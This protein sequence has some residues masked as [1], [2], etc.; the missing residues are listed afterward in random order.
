MNDIVDT[1]SINTAILNQIV[2]DEDS[3]NNIDYNVSQKNDCNVE[4]LNNSENYRKL[5]LKNLGC[6]C[7]LNS[8]L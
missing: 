8:I 3:S 1:D 5:G 4:Q 2:N 6:T 7:Y